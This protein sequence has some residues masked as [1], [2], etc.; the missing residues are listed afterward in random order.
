MD[1]GLAGKR[2]FVG[3]G[4]RG[5][6]RAIA[7]SLAGEG[8]RVAVVARPSEDLTAVATRA[9]AVEV[10]ADLETA[11][12]I[13]SAVERTVAQLGGLDLLLANSGG[14]KGGTFAEYDDAAWARAIEGTFQGT[15]RLIRLAL[16]HL[17][18]G[19]DPAIL[20]IL[21]SSVRV[22][23]PGLV[24]SNTLRPALAGLIKTLVEEIPPVRI[25]GI[26]PGR[27]A[28]DRVR[29]LDAARA[30][31]AGT[32]VPTVQAATI[33]QIPLGRYGHPDE[34]GRVGAFLLSPAASYVDGAIISVDGGMIKALP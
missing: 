34:L 22:P 31:R 28:T 18:Q 23:I 14:P 4:S 33:A 9:G 1:L 6:G 10:G 21:S 32:D 30:A 3:G 11:E 26:A 19:T 12:G 16:P 25:N 13:A 20:I 27:F 29:E 5:L 7:E 17:R 8:A 15:L 24:A 2:A